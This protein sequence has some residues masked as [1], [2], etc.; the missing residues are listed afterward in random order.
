MKKEG[1]GDCSRE[2]KVKGLIKRGTEK[3][4][5]WN[6]CREELECVRK[7]AREVGMGQKNERSWL[8]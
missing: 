5:Q 8:Y 1:R 6:P 7:T 2:N 3:P 4:V